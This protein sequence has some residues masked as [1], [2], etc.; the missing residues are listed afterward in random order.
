MRRQ[1]VL[2]AVAGTAVLAVASTLAVAGAGGGGGGARARH[3]RVANRPI[4]LLGLPGGGREIFPAHRVIAYYGAPGDPRLG[5]LGAGPPDVIAKKV[6]RQAAAYSDAGQSVLPALELIATEA[7][8]SAGAD[9]LYRVRQPATVVRRY[10]SA[11]RHASALLIIDLQPGR[12]DFLTEAQVYAQFLRE[13]D[14]SLALDPEW[15]LAAG[16]LPGQQ[17]GSTDA[18]AINRVSAFLAGIIASGRLPQKLLIVHQ[19]TT[20]MVRERT[21]ILPRAGVAITINID[22]FGDRPNKIAKYRA[23]SAP[24]PYI[25]SGFKLFYRQD[26]DLLSPRLV[27]RLQPSPNLV[28]YQ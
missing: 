27:M 28:V 1:R 12:S 11:A 4:R 9:G 3:P 8:S 19:F 17:I 22:G 6:Q 18:A 26:V 14:V 24:A 25:F 16:Q 5:V 2:V 21:Q 15:Q 13:P 10:L 20:A 23:L 7:T